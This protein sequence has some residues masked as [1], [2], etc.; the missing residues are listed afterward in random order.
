MSEILDSGERREFGTGAVRDVQ[1]GKG[2]CGTAGTNRLTAARP[3]R[4]W[5]DER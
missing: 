1:E 2:R 3:E 4:W 5:S